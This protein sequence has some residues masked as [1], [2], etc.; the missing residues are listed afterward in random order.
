M[1]KEEMKYYLT[2]IRE[3]RDLSD[4][5][6]NDENPKLEDKKTFFLRLDELENAIKLIQGGY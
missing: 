1:S 6:L 4:M 3:I 2:L 5:L